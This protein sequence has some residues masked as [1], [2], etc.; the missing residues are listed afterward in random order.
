MIDFDW[1]NYI[2]NMSDFD[3]F[4]TGQA[5][6]DFECF[7]CMKDR[8]QRAFKCSDQLSPP[9][10]KNDSSRKMQEIFHAKNE[11]ALLLKERSFEQW[12]LFEC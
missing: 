4:E 10:S 11:Q 9:L 12:S 5:V 2:E 7:K 3:Y 8:K 6:I 1:N